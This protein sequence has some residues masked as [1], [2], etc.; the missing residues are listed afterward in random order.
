MENRA[1]GED[2]D[3]RCTASGNGNGSSSARARRR[4]ARFPPS[5]LPLLLLLLLPAGRGASAQGLLA[6]VAS[7]QASG[8]R[9]YSW[10]IAAAAAPPSQRVP[11]GG[12]ATVLY[13]VTYTR[14][15]ASAELA[16]S[17][18]REGGWG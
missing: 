10:S 4:G 1:S 13:T 14:D 11:P 17:A 6:S 15:L 9:Q 7:L 3:A 8:V 5:P 2:A 18:P 16:V 12:N